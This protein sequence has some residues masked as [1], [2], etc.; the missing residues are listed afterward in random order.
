MTPAIKIAGTIHSY[1]SR[2]VSLVPLILLE[3]EWIVVNK[4]MN[5]DF[6]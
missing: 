6:Y 2:I 3:Y 4:R 5:T 1:E